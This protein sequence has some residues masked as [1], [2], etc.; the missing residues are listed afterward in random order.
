MFQCQTYKFRWAQILVC[1]LIF[2]CAASIVIGQS[3]WRLIGTNLCDFSPLV[4]A[5]GDVPYRFQGKVSHIYPESIRVTRVVG[6]GFA[7]VQ[8]SWETI[9]NASPGDM[10]NQL[11]AAHFAERGVDIGDIMAMSPEVRQN[12]QPVKKTADFYLLNYPFEVHVGSSIDCFALPTAT[13]GFWDYG[14]PFSGDISQFKIIYHVRP[15]GIVAEH[16]YSPKEKKAMK[17]ATDAKVVTWL[18]S[19]ATNGDSSAQCSLGLHYLNGQ[20]VETNK[21]LAVEWLKKAAD[22]GDTEASNKLEQL[23]T[24]QTNLSVSVKSQ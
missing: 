3:D 11:S 21:A 10:L 13:K 1:A 17:Q 12:L 9:Q 2:F 8:P 16:L 23:T 19:Q 5:T 20:G 18:L 22:Q 6:V 7:Y 4:S 14:Q 24:I 15:T